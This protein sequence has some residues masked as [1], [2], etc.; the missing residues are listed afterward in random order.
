MVEVVEVNLNAFDELMRNKPYAANRLLF[1]WLSDDRR[2]LDLYEALRDRRVLKFQSRAEIKNPPPQPPT[3][4]QD[5][6]LVASAD[7]IKEALSDSARFSNTPYAALGTGT[8]MLALNDRDPAHPKQRAF[9]IDALKSASDP[10]HL[11][12][13]I[14]TAFRVAAT[15]P[16]KKSEFDLAQLAEQTALRFAGLM[17]GYLAS[18]H[19]ML[20][21]TLSRAFRGLNY[22]ILARHFVSEPGTVPDATGAMGALLTRTA[23]LIDQ[24]ASSGV[25]SE[26]KELYEK[27]GL[28]N[29]SPAFEVMGQHP[30]ELSGTE[31]AIAAVGTLV[32][33][34]GNVQASVCIAVNQIFEDKELPEVAR[35]ARDDDF[36]IQRVVRALKQHPPAAFLPRQAI[37]DTELGGEKIPKDSVL[38]LA[39]G[40]ANDEALIFGGNNDSYGHRCLGKHLALPLIVSM[41]KQVVLLP[42]LAR[43]KDVVTGDPI[44]LS[45]SWGFKCEKFPLRYDR[46][47]VLIQQPLNVIMNVKQPVPEN[48]AKLKLVIKYGAPQIESSLTASRHVHFAWF[49]F[50]ENDTKLALFT[51]YDGDFDAYIEHFALQVG[52]LFDR[53]LEHI[54][55]APPRP[56]RQF[57]KEF[58]ETIRRYNEAPV[59]GYFF[60]AYTK[61][62]VAAIQGAAT[63]A[64]K[65]RKAVLQ[66]ALRMTLVESA[67]IEHIAKPVAARRPSGIDLEAAQIQRI[68]VVWVPVAV[69]PPLRAGNC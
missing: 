36:V 39:M 14:R 33:I 62:S 18:D 52:P 15:L 54:E 40:A 34:I 32:G 47:Q 50:L 61:Q 10:E 22:Q 64:E 6:F 56:V 65:T 13:L 38:I 53:L 21:N 48:A 26:Q 17:F 11:T 30:A 9:V 31:R 66:K 43:T 28:K 35:A 42:G 24:Y 67:N 68:V 29:F 41:V 46:D 20:E 37:K 3:F 8:F 45:K 44:R 16:L 23:A 5:V 55:D 7:L 58:V 4:R 59:E 27:I 51:T 25:P 49:V 2:R 63:A 57:P 69:R 1:D 60:S 12:A 19:P